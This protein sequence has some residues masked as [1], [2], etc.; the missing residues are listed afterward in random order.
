MTLSKGEKKSARQLFGKTL[1][2]SKFVRGELVKAIRAGDAPPDAFKQVREM[3]K[4]ITTVEAYMKQE[5]L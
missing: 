2:L 3:D 1:E 5:K 4:H